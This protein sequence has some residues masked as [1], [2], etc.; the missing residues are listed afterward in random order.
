M[1]KTLLKKNRTYRRFDENECIDRLQ[2]ERWLEVVR[3]TASMRNVQPLKYIIIT[4]P[5]ECNWITAQVTWAG[6]LGDWDGPAEGERPAAY[7]VQ[8]LDTNIAASGRFDEGL[9]LEAITLMAVEEGYGACILRSFSSA[10]FV[11]RYG[12]PENLHPSCLIALGRP[13]EEVVIEDAANEDDI[14]YWHDEK[15][16]HHVPK[17]PL[18]SLIIE[19]NQSSIF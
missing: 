1:L 16:V 10:E 13:V 19:P 11:R 3:Y 7:L 15:G 18:D 12:L 2:I 9:Q 8:V 14:K 4:D 17:R 5:E 6:Y